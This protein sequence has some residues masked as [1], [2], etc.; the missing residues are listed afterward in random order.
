MSQKEIKN[1]Q[2]E[3]VDELDD[4]EA[5]IEAMMQAVSLLLIC[6]WHHSTP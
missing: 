5:E 2:D 6:V 1:S 3:F 4:I